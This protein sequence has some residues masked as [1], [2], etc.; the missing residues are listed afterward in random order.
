M[1]QTWSNLV[2][3]LF[4]PLGHDPGCSRQG[5]AW[6]LHC[7]WVVTVPQC[8]VPPSV[9][10]IFHG[11][12]AICTYFFI[13]DAANDSQKYTVEMNTSIFRKFYNFE[14]Q[15]VNVLLLLSRLFVQ[16]VGGRWSVWTARKIPR[17][18]FEGAKRHVCPH[19][20]R[21]FFAPLSMRGQPAP[22][23]ASAATGQPSRNGFF[24]STQPDKLSRMPV[25]GR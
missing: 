12:V 21:T 6:S 8:P 11:G 4:K 15:N 25:T 18:N 16:I 10:R 7:F 22:P 23:P 9:W 24:R 17:E 5:P 3:P 20:F 2:C 1:T 13:I 14:L 19:L